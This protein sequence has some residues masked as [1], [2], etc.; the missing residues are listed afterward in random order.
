LAAARTIVWEK[1]AVTPSD[2]RLI[3]R[4]PLDDE[5]SG[6]WRGVFADE[7]QMETGL[8]VSTGPIKVDG[9]NVVTDIV[10]ASVAESLRLAL[11]RTVERTNARTAERLKRDKEQKAGEAQR[12]LQYEAQRLTQFFRAG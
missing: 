5:P 11:R 10:D 3:L 2:G 1:A 6:A 12:Q 7:I 8:G 4:V 9:D